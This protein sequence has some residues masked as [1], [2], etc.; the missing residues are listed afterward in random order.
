M[1][2][3]IERLS[4]IVALIGPGLWLGVDRSAFSLFFNGEL[5]QEVAEI[6]ADRFAMRNGC[7]CEID[8]H[9]ARF[10]RAY[11]KDAT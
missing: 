7:T 11:A 5:S 3:P 6:E 9:G 10:S 4:K 2:N 8:E 1:E